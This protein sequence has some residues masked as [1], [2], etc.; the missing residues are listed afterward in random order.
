MLSL[1]L[2]SL[3]TWNAVMV[4]KNRYVLFEYGKVLFEYGKYLIYYLIIDVSCL[5]FI[6]SIFTYIAYIDCKYDM[7]LICDGYVC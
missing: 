1:L 2:A 6:Y 4:L 7:I 5:T 3:A